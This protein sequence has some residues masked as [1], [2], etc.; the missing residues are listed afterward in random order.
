MR[1]SDAFWKLV[2]D[3]LDDQK[4]AASAPPTDDLHKRAQTAS[5]Q[6]LAWQLLAAEAVRR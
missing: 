4:H 5:I 6:A 1:E 2:V 3:V